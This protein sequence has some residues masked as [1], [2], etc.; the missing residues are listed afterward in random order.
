MVDG[1]SEAKLSPKPNMFCCC[2]CGV[3]VD[4]DGDD[5]PL[6]SLKSNHGAQL[7]VMRFDGRTTLLYPVR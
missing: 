7:N 5:M 3:D 1:Q 4:D 2:C 6:E